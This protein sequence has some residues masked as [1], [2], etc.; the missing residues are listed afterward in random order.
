[1]KLDAHVDDIRSLDEEEV[2]VG[3]LV[4]SRLDPNARGV[5]V[6]FVGLDVVTVLWSTPPHNTLGVDHRDIW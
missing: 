3:T 2:A 1:M 5:V 4:V 6:E